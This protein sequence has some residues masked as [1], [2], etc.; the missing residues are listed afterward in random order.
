M[1]LL[2]NTVYVAS[3]EARLLAALT[4]L[5]AREDRHPVPRSAPRRPAPLD[6]MQY[7]G[8]QDNPLWA[9]ALLR[10][11]QWSALKS[12]PFDL[13]SERSPGAPVPRL[14]VLAQHLGCA[15]F[16]LNAYDG[17][18][19]VLL[20]ADAR[21]RLRASGFQASRGE[22]TF[23]DEL[24]DEGDA[25]AAFR[26]LDVP[27]ALAEALA[28]GPEEAPAAVAAHLLDLPLEAWFEQASNAVQV[29]GLIPHRPLGVGR[30]V[31][32]AATATAR[33]R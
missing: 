11:P 13:P 18:S 6:P 20:E 22:L 24:V 16:Q 31:Y 10:G 28:L 33:E 1:E 3:G 19:L 32:F 7:G 9:L 2:D 25:Q 14:A 5:F 4:T 26:L 23:H 29:Q 30:D 27:D 8:A 17:D 21:G 15:A 12:A